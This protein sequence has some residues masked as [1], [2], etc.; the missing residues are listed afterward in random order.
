MSK[1]EKIIEVR[2]AQICEIPPYFLLIV[3]VF[4]FTVLFSV[5]TP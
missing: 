1:Q 5:L 3:S 2:G 4:N